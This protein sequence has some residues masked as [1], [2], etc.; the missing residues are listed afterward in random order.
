VTQA[1]GRGRAARAGFRR[2]AQA[3]APVL[4]LDLD[5]TLAPLVERA[6]NARVPAATR[7]VLDRLR[8]T[9]AR[10]VIVSG[11]S[12]AGVQHVAQLP[13]DAILGDHGALIWRGRG[14]KPWLP[15][16]RVA[17]AR[18][19]RRVA[20]ELGR[21]P[22]V[23]LEHK[24]RSLAIHLRLSRSSR[25][26]VIAEVVRL[27]EQTGL[28]VLHGHRVIDAQLPG[29]NKGSAVKRWLE[30]DE[31]AD[32]V[33]YAGDD[34]TDEDAFRA[35]R[36]RGMTVSVGPRA[37]GAGFRTRDPRSFATWLGRLA[38]ARRATR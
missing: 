32:A 1:L 9:G 13:T 36:G 16:D 24:D 15:A 37:R 31:A 4:F 20:L 12:I 5:G 19:V 29:V 38:E 8:R 22:G 34:T 18:A 10:V 7:R 35:L 2:L 33:I 17:L 3:R 25:K 28:R 27:L 11:R 14:L 23:R 30:T 26:G 21:L 6:E